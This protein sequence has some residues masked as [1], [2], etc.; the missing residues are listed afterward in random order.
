MNKNLK[1]LQNFFFLL[2]MGFSLCVVQACSGDD[3]SIENPAQNTTDIA[4]TGSVE[5]CG[6]SYA[7]I[8]GY[9]NLNLLPAGSGNPQ[10]GIEIAIAEK[11]DDYAEYEI[12]T[13]MSGNCFTVEFRPLN[14]EMKYKYRSFVEYAGIKH[15]GEYKTFTTKDVSVLL[16][17]GEATE[18][19]FTSATISS[20]IHNMKEKFYMVGVLCSTSK[21]AL[22]LD[23][24]YTS[25]V[26]FKS[27]TGDFYENIEEETFYNLKPAT[28]YYYASVVGI[29]KDEYLAEIKSFTTKGLSNL[30]TTGDVS[31]ITPFTATV[32]S[33]VVQDAIDNNLK[34]GIA[35]STSETA[36]HPD[37]VFHVEE[38][39]KE[40]IATG[41]C[42]VTLKGLSASTTYYYASFVELNGEYRFAE[43]KNFTSQRLSDLITGSEVV[44]I[45]FTRA[46]I[47]LSVRDDIKQY[48]G[49]SEM[50]VGVAYSTSQSA[51]HPDS[52]FS[53]RQTSVYSIEDGTCTFT[54]WGL[55]DNTTYYYAPFIYLD[56]EYNFAEIKSFTTK[57]YIPTQY[58]AVDLGLSVKWAACNVGASSPEEYGGYY[59]W[60]ETEEKSDYDWETYKWC[61]GSDGFMTK[62]CTNSS[63]GA[64]DNKTVLD[65]EDDVAHVKLGGNWRMPTEEE[66]DEL[67]EKCTWKWFTFNGVSGQLIIG[68]NDNS[69]FLPAAGNFDGVSHGTHGR[70]WTAT[71]PRNTNYGSLLYFQSGNKAHI[72]KSSRF[73]GRSVRPV[74]D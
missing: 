28:T 70:Y 57:E 37:S 60:G 8:N 30:T 17:T 9:A 24:I 46:T 6:C 62:Y 3:E 23:S 67:I 47:N 31:D 39:S 73:I 1:Y 21:S 22:H 27:E 16:S 44:D 36:L 58:G 7:K 48:K 63:Y 18:V 66:I 52:I 12:A 10:I 74:T 71:M 69:I 65:P 61:N 20:I 25:S 14:P 19:S 59:A 4:V 64:V 55:F 34:V 41:T 51:L 53:V 15:Y 40:D 54:L 72:V 35:Y 43:I 38:F 68:P 33:D 56:G 42:S 49:W 5:E 32:T 13:S 11:D 2:M 45:V 50:S 29:V 26:M